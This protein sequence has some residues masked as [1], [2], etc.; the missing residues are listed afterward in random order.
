[1]TS[2][3]AERA[4]ALGA[5]R[6]LLREHRWAA[7]ATLGHGNPEV[8][9][10]AYAVHDALE[11]G[12][13]LHVSSLA[14]H[15]RNFEHCPHASLGVSE[16]EG[17]GSDP[18]RLARLALIGS[19]SI[20]QPGSECHEEATH[21]YQRRLPDSVPLFAFADFR[22]IRFLPTEARFVAG[23]ARAY[24]FSAVDLERA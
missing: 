15:T 11:R 19:V 13:V 2:E 16:Q 20:L 17:T 18:Q 6:R 10:V 14:A 3:H 8:S 9:W 5:F 22:L 12:I 24:T 1:M 7:L 4:E 23:F 21:L